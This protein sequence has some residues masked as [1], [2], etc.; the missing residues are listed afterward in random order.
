MRKAKHKRFSSAE[1]VHTSQSIGQFFNP[2][3]GGIGGTAGV[4]KQAR[5][6]L[7]DE[8]SAKIVQAG[9]LMRKLVVETKEEGEEKVEDA[10]R[11]ANE[12]EK[13][14]ALEAEKKMGSVV[15]EMQTLANKNFM[16]D[17]PAASQ[18]IV[19]HVLKMETAYVRELESL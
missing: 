12:V 16:E 8:G 18:G 7:E 13:Q 5:E 19:G 10:E 15:A 9:N 17:I 11:G 14:I 4:E 1:P 2:F 3:S 6:G